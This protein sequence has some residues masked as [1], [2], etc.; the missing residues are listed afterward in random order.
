MLYRY[1]SESGICID[2][3]HDLPIVQRNAYFKICRLAFEMCVF[4]RQV[5]KHTEVKEFFEVQKDR[6]SLGLITVDK[7]A[8]KCGFQRLYTFF[9]SNVSRVF[10]SVLHF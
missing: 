9:S 10:S 3:I 4:S 5:M 6:D 8:T 2:T 7:M 1:D